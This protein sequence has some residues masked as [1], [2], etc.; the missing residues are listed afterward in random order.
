VPFAASADSGWQKWSSGHRYDSGSG[1]TLLIG[2]NIKLVIA[3]Q[4]YS[5]FCDACA[6]SAHLSK[7]ATPHKCVLN[8]TGSSKGME[9]TGA[10]ALVVFIW[11]IARAWI[12]MLVC[13]NDATVRSNMK[14]ISETGLRT[15][16]TSNGPGTKQQ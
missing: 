4:V 1:Q 5:T 9:A 14:H 13:N 15:S 10:I 16:L 12:Q 11:N 6:T 8:Y 2:C 3:R 7:V